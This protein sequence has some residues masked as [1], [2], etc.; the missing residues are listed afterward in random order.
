MK[1]I[2][3][4]LLSTIVTVVIAFIFLMGIRGEF[5]RYLEEKYSGLSF[6]IG[7]VMVDPLY[8]KFVANVTC[9]NDETHFPISKSFTTKAIYED[10]PQSKSQ[11]QYNSKLKEIFAG[12]DIESFIKNMTGG[13]K[14]P[15]ENGGMYTQ[16]NI[17]LT[18][19]AEH[20]PV[21]KKMLYV[22]NQNHI[23]AEI[24]IFT[25]DKDQHVFEIHV[26]SDD[27]A[28]TEKEIEAKI[29]KIK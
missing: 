9:L 15:F 22:L 27:H 23:S 1:L 28:L 5:T 13:G 25:Y 19:G 8:G 10:Y 29:I 24:I 14:T 16:I 20:I 17:R 12:S 11:M 4:I 6:K 21:I 3:M 26:S 18:D 7:F 2:K